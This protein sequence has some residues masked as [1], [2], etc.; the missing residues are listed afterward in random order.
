[1]TSLEMQGIYVNG[2]KQPRL[3]IM[4][5]TKC[6]KLRWQME[7]LGVDNV[8]NTHTPCDS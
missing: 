5:D 2:S 6:W 8:A 7:T 3:M 4:V 1:M